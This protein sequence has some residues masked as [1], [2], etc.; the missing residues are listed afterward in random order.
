M[1]QPHPFRHVTAVVAVL[2]ALAAAGCASSPVPAARP[3]QADSLASRVV[4]RD[5]SKGGLVLPN[6]ERP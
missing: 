1:K 3:T 2:V 6:P 5:L 4:E